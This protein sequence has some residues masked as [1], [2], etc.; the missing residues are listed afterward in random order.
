MRRAR[1]AANEINM[2]TKEI[3]MTTEP[4]EVIQRYLNA[5]VAG[6]TEAIRHSFAE[7]ATWTIYGEI[8]IAGPWI[9]RDQIVD[10][11]LT[12]GVGLLFEP[13]SHTF[14]F[15]TLI[16]EGN[17]I[18]LEWRV[19]ARTATGAEYNN[20]YCGI[21]IVDDGRIQTVREYLD[22]GYAARI[23]FP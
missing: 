1:C 16:T 21:F 12:A 19:H 17:T 11:F 3:D 6:D 22:S 5:L 7:D 10:D 2:S 8:P 23:L 20:N 15:P 18:A 4:K 13:G 9:G 14:E